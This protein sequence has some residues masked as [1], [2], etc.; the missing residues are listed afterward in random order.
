MRR[1]A[2]QHGAR[3][4]HGLQARSGVHEVACDH[5]LVGRTDGDR[6]LPGDHAGPGPD[7]RAEGRHGV[8][9]LERGAHGA[10]GVVLVGGR[11]APD[12]HDRIADELLDGPSIAADELRRE[13]EIPRQHLPDVLG[14][15]FLGERREADEVGEQDRDQ[16]PL[17]GGPGRPD[18][19][20]GSRRPDSR[21]GSG[22]ACPGE[23]GAA[24][25]TELHTG[26]RQRPARGARGRLIGPAFRAEA[27]SRHD[28]AAAG[29]ADQVDR[30]SMQCS[31]E[32]IGTRAD[33]QRGLAGGP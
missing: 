18:S 22:R 4:G 25:G 3:R 7:S 27:G 16:A 8:D 31:R 30:S 6:S 26:P 11:R 12:G 23:A 17:G 19:R 5:A 28:V 24:L 29:G 33:Q 1:L 2:H 20:G 13:V 10:L 32:P 9:Q 21:G 14:V 15:A